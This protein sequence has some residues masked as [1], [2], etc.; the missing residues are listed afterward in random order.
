MIARCLLAAAALLSLAVAP[1]SAAAPAP[2]QFVLGFAALHGAAPSDVGGC[3]DNQTFAANGDAVQ[4]TSAGLLVWRKSDNWTAFTN[5]YQTWLN[6][7]TGLVKRFNDE[8]FEWEAYPA[9]TDGVPVQEDPPAPASPSEVSLGPL[10]HVDQTLD[11][12]GPAAIGEVLRYYGFTKSQQ[13]LEAS[14]RPNNPSGM[15]TEVIRPYVVTLGLR[16]A[17]QQGATETQL[18]NLIRA[19]L[20]PIVEQTVSTDDGQLHYRALEGFDDRLQQ[21]VAA[22]TLLGPRHVISYAEF[23]RIWAAT[24]H[25][26]VV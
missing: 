11:N 15:T 3:V 8:W 26:L 19:G 20:P 25:E 14:L 23:D 1:V 4:H 9:E 6:G 12:C 17:V 24:S 22:D 2:C 13:E 16:A 10:I 5:G 18:K 21:F 7:P